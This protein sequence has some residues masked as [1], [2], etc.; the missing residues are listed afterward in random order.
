MSGGNN[1]SGNSGSGNSGSDNGG[2]RRD[3]ELL[4]FLDGELAPREARAVEERLAGS[5]DD[6]MKVEA[7]QQL[8]GVLRGYYQAKTEEAAPQLD[9]LWGKLEAQLGTPERA[10]A[11]PKSTRPVA[12]G[13][14]WAAIRDWFTDGA[15]GYVVTGAVCAAA[16]VIITVWATKQEPKIIERERIVTVDRPVP[17]PLP[18]EV[19]AR[20]SKPEVES[21]EVAGGTG[22]VAQIPG[23]ADGEG[24]STV[25]WVVREGSGSSSTA[26]EGPI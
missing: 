9:A 16:A 3:D 19:M 7:M 23:D 13:G 8:G 25:I 14:L 26:P 17:A 15:R 11:A 2:K 20:A 1:S 21:L 6:Q 5:Q 4:A 24:A 18:P 22:M 10:P 12:D